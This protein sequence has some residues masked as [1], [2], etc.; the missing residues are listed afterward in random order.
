MRTK[1]IYSA[2]ILISFIMSFLILANHQEAIAAEI[3]YE[4]NWA[5]HVDFE[6]NRT[7][8]EL[9]VEVWQFTD[10]VE[11]YH[12][13]TTRRLRCRVPNSVKISGEEATFSGDGGIRCRVPSLHQIIFDMTDGAFIAPEECDCKVGAFVESEIVLDPNNTSQKRVNPVFTMTDLALEAEMPP[14]LNPI[15]LMRFYVDTENAFSGHF[16]VNPGL[17]LLQAEFDQVNDPNGGDLVYQPLFFANGGQL[18]AFPSEIEE[19]LALSLKQSQIYIGFSPQTGE[20]LYGRIKTL[21][22]D[23]GCFGTG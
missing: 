21:D 4:A 20:A 23:P 18:S 6:G 17:N 3:A 19:D 9:T 1:K 5:I 12:R 13:G 16:L 8:A 14:V 22:V 10:G 15:A 2:G 7:N 11:T